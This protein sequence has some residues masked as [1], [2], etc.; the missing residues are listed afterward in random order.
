MD[1][2]IFGL[3]YVGCVSLGCLAKNGHHMIGVDLNQEKVDFINTG[4]ASII[5]EKIEPIISEYHKTG[6][7]TATT[8]GVRAVL[9][10]EISIICVGTPSTSSGHLEL[11]AVFS[12][13][14]EIGNAI[15]TKSTFHVIIIRSTV[16]P[17]TNEKVAR[18]IEKFS[19]KV[20]DKHFAVVS[21][22][23]FLRE[24]TA[25]LD[26]YNPPYTLIGATSKKAI[27]LVKQMYKDIDAPLIVA[28]IK[29]AELMKYVNNAFHA[30]KIIF[31]NEIG[32]VCKTMGAD[33]H[34]LMDIFCMDTKLNI[35]P[36]YLKPGFAYGGSCLPKDLKAL[37][38]I[39]HDKYLECPVLESIERSNEFQKKLVLE[40][41]IQFG[42]MKIGF[43]GLSFKGGTDDLRNSPILDVIET[44][45]GK[46]FDIRIYDRNVR[47]S[48][49]MGANKEY[50][51]KKIPY[52][53][54]FLVKKSE[55]IIAHSDVIV[56]VN[57]EKE[58]E[59]I[60]CRATEDKIIYDLVDIEFEGRQKIKN[61]IGIAW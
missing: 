46:G 45:L 29:I 50:I 35:S 43:L 40:Q 60:L 54:K 15:K 53:S 21:N 32:N 14:E 38:T 17:G 20:K 19:G 7:I 49:L 55:T 28:D 9:E 34:K 18:I 1:I 37:K 24:G 4:R 41:I 12:V 57:K 11:G 3:G 61:Y 2:S 26:Y 48:K 25:V 13:A 31:A 47:F 52:V 58:F 56:V 51:L 30:L 16:L 6:S 39:A 8:D 44:L 33:S 42:K 36:Y 5:E 59:K 22:P 27:N 23:E 10:T